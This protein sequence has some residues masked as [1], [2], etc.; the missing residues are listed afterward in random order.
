MSPSNFDKET[1]RDEVWAKI[2]QE[3]L[4][5]V[6]PRTGKVRA[7][8]VAEVSCPVCETSEA[9]HVFSKTG[10][11]F[12]R[13]I[14]CSTIYVNPQ[15]REDITLSYYRQNSQQESS[16]KKSSAMWLDVLANPKNQAWQIPYFEEALAI[17]ETFIPARGDIL[18]IGCSIGLF[19]EI[20]QKHAFKCTGLELES[21][22]A[23]YALNKGLNVRQQTLQEA[24]FPANSFDAI[25][26]FGVLEHLKSPK[27]V[28]QQAFDCL[29]PGGVMMAIVP[30]AYSLAA[31]TLHSGSKMFNGRNHL[32][33]FSWESFPLIFENSG[34]IVRN[35]DTCLTG[36]D[37]ILNYWQFLDSQGDAVLDYLPPKLRSLVNNVDGRKAIEDLICKYDLGLRL[38]VVAQKSTS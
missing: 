22:A 37:S 3:L 10:F 8:L 36:L 34:F 15:L 14:S 29:K 21:N 30:N 17:L 2:E 23:E 19:M 32:T 26:L 11:D 38:R 6:D 12:V 24:A 1:G 7:E 16:E 25:T 35:L 5:L 18:D 27:V 28:L 33:Y 20:A 31:M 9:R 13:C 4:E